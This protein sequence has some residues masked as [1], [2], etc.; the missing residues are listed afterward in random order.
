MNEKCIFKIMYF[1][2]LWKVV[3]DS[4]RDEYRR[5]TYRIMNNRRVVEKIK[6]FTDSSAIELCMRYAMG[7]DVDIKWGFVS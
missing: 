2:N 3:V 4:K 7:C 5:Y 6:R 1:G